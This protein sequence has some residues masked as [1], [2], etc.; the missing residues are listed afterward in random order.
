MTDAFASA[1]DRMSRVAGV[2]GALIVEKESGV[3]VLA[4]LTEGV[5]GTAVAALAGSLFRRAGHATETTGLG[6]LTIL[7]L[8]ADDGHVVAVDA[9]ELVL[10]V[11]AERGAQLGMVRVEALEAARTLG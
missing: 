11:V 2:R 9:G 5:N 6:V 10:V 3:Q 7:Q 1:V 8:D 4:E